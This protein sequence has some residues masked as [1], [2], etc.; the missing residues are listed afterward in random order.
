M[1]VHDNFVSLAKSHWDVAY[2]LQL[3]DLFEKGIIHKIEWKERK[4]YKS[5]KWYTRRVIDSENTKWLLKVLK[6]LA[7][8]RSS[9]KNIHASFH[10]T[11]TQKV[12]GMITREAIKRQDNLHSFAKSDMVKNPDGYIDES[13]NFFLSMT[14]SKVIIV[15]APGYTEVNQAI[16]EVKQLVELWIM[17]AHVVVNKYRDHLAKDKEKTKRAYQ[18]LKDGL[19]EYDIGVSIVDSD[20]EM[21]DYDADEKKKK[22]ISRKNLAAIAEVV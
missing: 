22:A 7:S 11:M 10:W 8:V 1:W 4:S 2:I 3:L 16:T 18:E 5:K 21:I 19:Q 9:I 15:T 13:V 20:F 17:P 14:K 12:G 6:S